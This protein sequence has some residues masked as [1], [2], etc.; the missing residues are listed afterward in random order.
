MDKIGPED[1]Q[2]F[3]DLLKLVA[4][5]FFD[6]RSFVDPVTDVNV[7]FRASKAGRSAL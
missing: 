3:L 4:D 2:A 5:F 6:G 1:L 7:H